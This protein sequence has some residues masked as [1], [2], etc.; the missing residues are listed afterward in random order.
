MPPGKNGCRRPLTVKPGFF[1]QKYKQSM[2]KSYTFLY[3][4]SIAR[5]LPRM[6]ANDSKSRVRQGFF[7]CPHF[8]SI[9][10]N[11]PGKANIYM[12]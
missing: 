7:A 8:N 11:N 12:L 2:M 6:L 3:F 1:P 4:K 5:L 10:A 9:L